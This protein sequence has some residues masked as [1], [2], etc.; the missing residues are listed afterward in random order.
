MKLFLAIIICH[1]TIV[2]AG[3]AGKKRQTTDEWLVMRHTQIEKRLETG[4]V[5]KSGL[6]GSYARNKDGYRDFFPKRNGLI[7]FAD[8]SWVVITSHSIHKGS[9]VGDVTL[10]KTSTGKYY[11]NRG[12]C[13]LS[14]IIRSKKERIASLADFLATKGVGPKGELLDW[15]EYQPGVRRENQ[16]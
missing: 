5:P 15:K 8:G 14:M 16:G 11:V 7:R 4:Q 2:S 3:R 13:C 10:V 6:R 12:H 1:F 9:G